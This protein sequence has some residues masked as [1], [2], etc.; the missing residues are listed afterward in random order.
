[1]LNLVK[2]EAPPRIR[3]YVITFRRHALLKRAL[4]SVLGQTHRN[5]EVLV[6]NDDPEDTEV[7]KIVDALADSRVSLFL[8]LARRGPTRNFNL[9]FES[10]NTSFVTI[11]EDDNWWEPRFLEEMYEALRAHPEARLAVAN[12]TVWKETA[13]GQWLN[14]GRRIWDL[15]GL[16]TYDYSLEQ[17][18]GGAKLCNSSMLVRMSPDASYKVPESIPVDVT[19]H[20]RER[21]FSPPIVLVGNPLVNFAETLGTARLSTGSLWG[22]YQCLLIGSVFIA[23][24]DS[25]ARRALADRLWLSCSGKTSPRAVSLVTTGLSIKEARVLLL[26][27]PV[28]AIGRFLLWATR[29]PAQLASTMRLRHRYASQLEFLVRAPL[30]RRLTGA[31]LP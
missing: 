11:L 13:D 3:V 1:L 21:L 2:V 16:Q 9:P 20:F 5:F 19:E 12:E 27:A 22:I 28:A 24:P 4:E 31:A 30:T 6:I 14:T 15:Q 26:R 23:L 18:C 8:P 10:C 25:R 29:R 17:I 7:E